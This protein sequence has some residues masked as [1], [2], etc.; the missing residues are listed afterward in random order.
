MTNLVYSPHF[1]DLSE[2]VDYAFG[3]SFLGE[4]EKW[5]DRR[6][7][8]NSRV[9]SEDE[10]NIIEVEV[11]GVDPSDVNVRVEGRSLSVDTPRGSAYFT[12][13]Q[14]IDGEGAEAEL[15]NGLL[16]ITIPKR[17]AKVVHVKVVSEG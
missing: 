13:G 10:K 17:E 14:R 7:P 4:E 2:L 12:I 16:R 6:A 9:I 11:P 8:L 15:K 3:R 5:T 1:S